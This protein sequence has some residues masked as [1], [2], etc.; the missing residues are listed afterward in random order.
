MTKL[1]KSKL[2]RPVKMFK[3]YHPGMVHLPFHAYIMTHL[4]K[5][6]TALRVFAKRC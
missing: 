3:L 2:I 6:A 1:S 4:V 5:W